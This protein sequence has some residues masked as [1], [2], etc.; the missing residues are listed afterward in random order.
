MATINKSDPKKL[1]P[2]EINVAIKA[3]NNADMRAEDKTKVMIDVFTSMGSIK[4]G[5]D[6][7]RA[8]SIALAK[9]MDIAN[10]LKETNVALSK[11]MTTVASGN[12]ADFTDIQNNVSTY[13]NMKAQQLAKQDTHSRA[14]IE[15]SP[16]IRAAV[17]P[18]AE[19]VSKD[20]NL[21]NSIDGEQVNFINRIK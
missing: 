21:L 18:I 9:N 1:S 8:L 14:A 19:N 5:T 6:Q 11:F 13:S 10:D 3:V 15:S 20:V 12:D 16:A 7:H 2:K 4:A 17:Q